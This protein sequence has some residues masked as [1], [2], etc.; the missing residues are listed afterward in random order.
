VTFTLLPAGLTFQPT[1][2]NTPI[3]L[4]VTID[5]TLETV[6]LTELA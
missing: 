3:Q 4:Q 2:D 1:T 6:D 5:L